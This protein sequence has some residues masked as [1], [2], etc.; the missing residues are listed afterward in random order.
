MTQHVPSRLGTRQMCRFS[1]PC[2]SVLFYDISYFIAC[3][4]FPFEHVDIEENTSQNSNKNI[5]L[6][7][8][9]GLNRLKTQ[10]LLWQPSYR[11]NCK[12]SRNI[13]VFFSVFILHTYFSNT[14]SDLLK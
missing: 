2:Y 13:T 1:R 12:I 4:Y 3:F 14:D 9:N 6:E 11:R 8:E 10:Q 5:F 7:F